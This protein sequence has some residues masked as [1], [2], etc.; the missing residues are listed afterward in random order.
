MSRLKLSAIIRKLFKFRSY[1][2][3]NIKYEN[4]SIIVE[5]KRIRKTSDCPKC[6]RRSDNLEEE[7]TRIIRDLD[8]SGKMC[9]IVFVER[10]IKCSCG[11]RGIEKLDFVDKYA[12]Q[13]KR[14]EEYISRLCQLMCLKD[15]AILSKID[16]KTVKSIDKNYLKQLVIDLKSINPTGI[17]VDEVSYQKKHKY[18]TVVRDLD[19]GKVIWVHEGRTK[20]TLDLFFEE[21]GESKCRSIKVAVLD[22][23]DPYISSIQT[24]TN[25]DIVFD[26]FHIAKKVNEALDAVRKHEFANASDEERKNFKKKRFIILYRNENLDEKKREELNALMAK[27]ERLYQAYLLKEQILDI[28]DEQNEE[29]ASKRLD[30]WFENVAKADFKQFDKVVKTLK[31]YY[32][33]IKNYF[34]YHLTNAAS[35]GFNNKINVIKRRAYGFH[36]L[37]YLKLKILQSCGWNILR[38]PTIEFE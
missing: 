4:G 16:W 2:V 21:L 5:L 10:K 20:A 9:F 35:E 36:D 6:K 37:E 8:I 3:C 22:M 7:Y 12:R 33:G 38:L 34:K 17:G 29:N 24:N 11:Y 14:F 30:G 13:T 25:A 15:A 31:S 26:K 23:W 28:F 1:K 32:F 19:S 27:N 18:L